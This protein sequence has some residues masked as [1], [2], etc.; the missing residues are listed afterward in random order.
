MFYHL[1]ILNFLIKQMK[2]KMNVVLIIAVVLLGFWALRPFWEKPKSEE[3]SKGV[4]KEVIASG[5]P[6]WAPIMYRDGDKIAGAG[7]ELAEKV[8]T[9]LGITVNPKYVGS[10]DE[11]QAKAKDGSIDVI[12]A[13]YR[14]PEREEYMTYSVPYTVD[15]VALVVK[16]GKAFKYEKWEDLI[17]KKVVTT[18]GD[19]YGKEFDAFSAEKL[20]PTAVQTA[21][22]AF[23][24]L[25]KGKADYFVY[26]LYSAEGYIAKNKV[27][28]KFEI[29]ANPVSTEDFYLT[30]SKKSP[31]AGMMQKINNLIEKYKTDGTVEQLIEKNKQELWGEKE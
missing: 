27:S 29:I 15:P 5:H 20:K 12:V 21:D 14:T 4:V 23:G 28:D 30:V 6:E 10:W 26:A 3:G 17:G 8:F 22:E 16:K 19:S 18:I 13:A 1:I 25:E 24:L 9:D 7:M 2:D 11:V 31:I